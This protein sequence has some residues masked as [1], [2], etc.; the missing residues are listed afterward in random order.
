MPRNKFK[1][2]FHASGL[3]TRSG[4][5]ERTQGKH[6][7]VTANLTCRLVV[8]VVLITLL[9]S[10][11]FNITSTHS[12]TYLYPPKAKVLWS[13]G[14]LGFSIWA[15][16]FSPDGSL[17]AA[18][19]G[20][21]SSSCHGE[22]LV[23][24][25]VDGSLIW[26]S[27]DL[28]EYVW[29]LAFSPDGTKLAVG[30]AFGRVI[31]YSTYNWSELWRSSYLGGPVWSVAWSPDGT[32]LAVGTGRV[33]KAVFIFSSQ[34]T[35]LWS[36]TNLEG[37][38]YGVAW[39]K[40]G[41]MVVAGVGWVDANGAKHGKVI[42]LS[43]VDGLLEWSSLDLGGTINCISASP[44]GNE[45]VVG[46]S[47]NNIML[48]NSQGLKVWTKQLGVNVLSVS[49][50]PDGSKIAV[51]SDAPYVMLVN[52]SNGQQIWNSGPIS[53]NAL[54]TT[55]SVAWSP[56]GTKLAVGTGGSHEVIVF[57]GFGYGTIVVPAS[58]FIIR[59]CFFDGSVNNCYILGSK[60]LTLYADPG[61][62]V[63]KYYL[64]SIPSNVKYVGNATAL[65]TMPI[66]D[67]LNV[68]PSSK[69]KLSPPTNLTD[70]LG[71]IVI[72]APHGST[73]TIH[74][75]S[76]SKS[77]T[78]PQS[79]VISI[80][81]VPGE[82]HVVVE[83]S[84]SVDIGNS[85]G[86]IQGNTL[87]KDISVQRGSVA[88]LELK[89]AGIATLSIAGIP[90][91]LVNVT[92]ATGGK[93]YVIPDTGTLRLTAA[94][95]TYSV[96][97]YPSVP[98]GT[99]G[100]TTYF[101]SEYAVHEKVTLKAG[102]E[103]IL[104][105]FT[106]PKMAKIVIKGNEGLAVIIKWRSG[107]RRFLL[108][109]GNNVTVNAVPD[110]DYYVIPVNL[111]DLMP[112]NL[113]G[114]L[115]RLANISVHKH[116]YPGSTWVVNLS[117]SNLTGKL[118]IHNPSSVKVRV[119]ITWKDGLRETIVGSHAIV[120]YFAVPGEYTVNI[121]PVI[122]S[123][124]LGDVKKYV[125]TYSEHVRK[126]VTAGKTTSVDALRVPALSTLAI[127]AP[128]GSTVTV[129]WGN[130]ARSVSIPSGGKEDV[131]VVPNTRYKIRL[132][133]D[134][135]KHLGFSV[136]GNRSKLLLLATVEIYARPGKTAQ[137]DLSTK[138]TSAL[139][140]LEIRNNV[141]YGLK[142]NVTWGEHSEAYLVP[143]S[144]T[145][146]IYAVPGKYSVTVKPYTSNLSNVVGDVHSFEVT[147]AR[148]YE[149]TLGSGQR[150]LIEPSI[151]NLSE[152]LISTSPELRLMITWNGGE[153]LFTANSSGLVRV[154]A[155]PNTNYVIY[156]KGLPESIASEL[157][158]NPEKIFSTPL[159][160]VFARSRIVSIKLKL[161]DYLSR[162][163]IVN[164]SKSYDYRFIISWNGGHRIINLST[165]EEETLYAV[166]ETLNVTIVPSVQGILIG[167]V[168]AWSVN[169][170]LTL[171]PGEV[172]IC[173]A[174]NP[175]AL[176]GLKIKSLPG[177]HVTVVWGSG[178]RTLTV[179]NDGFVI[180]YAIPSKYE[181]LIQP[182]EL[183]S[184]LGYANVE[185]VPS[186][187]SYQ[188]MVKPNTW[189]S[190]DLTKIIASSIGELK[191]I[192]GNSFPV[193]VTISRVSGRTGSYTVALGAGNQA[194]LR[195]F[196]GTYF[197]QAIINPHTNAVTINEA[198]FS[199][200]VNVTGGSV[201]TVNIK[202]DAA[203][204]TFTGASAQVTIVNALSNEGIW[205]GEITEGEKILLPAGTY[206]IKATNIRGYNPGT[207]IAGDISQY[208]LNI[209]LNVDAGKAYTVN[210]IQ[211]LID[212]AKELT[213]KAAPGSTVIIKWG[214]NEQ[215]YV[216]SSSGILV[217]KLLPGQEYDV[218][219]LP[220]NPLFS[221]A[222]IRL[223][224]SS[225]KTCSIVLTYPPSQLFYAV[226]SLA[227][228]GALA[229]V[230]VAAI[231]PRVRIEIP[232]NEITLGKD[233]F[234]E[235][236]IVNKGIMPASV[237]VSIEIN[238]R[239]VVVDEPVR[240]KGHGVEV[241]RVEIPREFLEGI[242]HE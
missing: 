166:P 138:L 43:S 33:S 208:A 152:I 187:V 155:V 207:N 148:N 237:R 240:V 62:Y 111:K 224:P 168:K 83:P 53:G 66:S 137:V 198:V 94:P 189:V 87:V 13:S 28:G 225:L 20:W 6:L 114:D 109:A 238:G 29:A 158:G 18:G 3:N 174:P 23:F 4:S 194:T 122:P 131:S 74:W 140:A 5:Q 214:S 64:F 179:P 126:E 50:S 31:V 102:E 73:A 17:V 58:P 99:I 210:I 236:R 170:T 60:P 154:L 8:T 63:V 216:V 68:A 45:F 98:A 2:P 112:K 115:A 162:L 113:I 183:L 90:G 69:V 127:R 108:R 165:N 79:G 93:H 175:P 182:S 1:L 89:P 37:S 129:V 19:G 171:K 215:R 230:Y 222:R 145:G 157:L 139:A 151:S 82:Y 100:N 191:L 71:T 59:A 76:S 106:S 128:A 88:T 16:A 241:K 147:E 22:V 91:S 123:N 121:V 105:Y 25:S 21:C 190:E 84:V 38:V 188:V 231:R 242:E 221:E 232:A 235:V 178:R 134:V 203:L 95:G 47:F 153:H 202:L 72:K 220:T 186:K 144:T 141:N 172:K 120:E 211:H 193:Q 57:S 9:V 135:F 103:R 104:T 32:R 200:R 80:Y 117:V 132:N 161:T 96:T 107:A 86:F 41:S 209:R 11:F 124:V 136:A 239:K 229:V 81:A 49:F 77:F 48:F 14:D 142:V 150:K 85:Q 160:K 119:T 70:F 219:G 167:D 39:L 227:I 67:V 27:P 78:V 234:L 75:G 35:E 26:K 218:I 12:A 42:A 46:G 65:S 97:I 181:V 15:V 101:I 146:R 177:T 52:S 34:G 196:I 233:R 206:V 55:Y 61:K 51:G 110:C 199:R 130:G 226:F 184:K 169:N 195:C 176:G 149:V 185:G 24:S 56:D 213:I 217:V 159:T 228:C 164:P 30:G 10:V 92:W 44:T 173:S 192:N 197:I 205:S 163:R 143:P 7:T 204:V 156:V 118:M 36:K 223:N 201:F 116:L 40:N 54:A 180:L 125:A 212:S 133:D